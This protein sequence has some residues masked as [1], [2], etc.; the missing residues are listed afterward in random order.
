MGTRV[1]IFIV[2]ETSMGGVEGDLPRSLFPVCEEAAV[3]VNL[4]VPT[5]H[6]AF[7]IP[8]IYC[9]YDFC[10]VAVPLFD[11]FLLCVRGYCASYK[12]A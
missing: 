12:L 2:D 11:D 1:W 4:T 10:S 5:S 6:Y 7:S 3:P 9:W 8:P